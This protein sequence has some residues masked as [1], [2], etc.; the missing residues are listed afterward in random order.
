MFDLHFDRLCQLRR[1]VS[2][3]GEVGEDH[4][5]TLLQAWPKAITVADGSMG[6]S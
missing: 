1:P 3:G 5:P 4:A 2:A 6:C